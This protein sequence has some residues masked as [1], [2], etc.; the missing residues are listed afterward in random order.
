MAGSEESRAARTL[1]VPAVVERREGEAVVGKGER[2]GI[3]LLK[4]VEKRIVRRF[5]GVEGEEIGQSLD[6]VVMIPQRALTPHAV[7]GEAA[8]DLSA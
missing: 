2:R 1:R 7:L 3:H 8:G 4:N 6:G 5:Q